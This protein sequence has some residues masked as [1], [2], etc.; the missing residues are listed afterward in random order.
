MLDLLRTLGVAGCLFL[1]YNGYA[2]GKA[3]PSPDPVVDPIVDPDDSTPDPD[4]IAGIKVITSP[5]ES[6]AP[7]PANA[8]VAAASLPIV[9]VLSGHG[10]DAIKLARAFRQ[11]ADLIARDSTIKST[12]EFQ[13]AYVEAMQV[14][15]QR[16]SLAGK[17][18]LNAPTDATFDAA[19]ANAGLIDAAT[20]QVKSGPW[21][22]QAQAAAAEAFNAISY[23]CFKAY[24]ASQ[25]K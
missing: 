18:P 16:H 14:L 20:N 11:W 9:Q 24:L 12:D 23:Q 3:N 25:I 19:F 8:A 13:Q 5:P 17:Y 4:S 7:A 6:L 1:A 15:F 10:D 21:T 2:A 22:P